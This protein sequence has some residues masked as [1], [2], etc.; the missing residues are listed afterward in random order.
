MDTHKDMDVGRI[1][2]LVCEN[3]HTHARTHTHT[4][5]V[6]WSV[7]FTSHV[8]R[9]LPH[10]HNVL[11][12][13]SL[14]WGVWLPNAVR[15]TGDGGHVTGVW[16]WPGEPRQQQTSLT[17]WSSD[18]ERGR[19]VREEERGEG[20]ERVGWVA[21]SFAVCFLC[22]LLDACGWLW[23]RGARGGGG[24]GGGFLYLVSSV[25][26]VLKCGGWEREGWGGVTMRSTVNSSCSSQALCLFYFSLPPPFSILPH[27]SARG[28]SL[29][30]GGVTSTLLLLPPTHPTNSFPSSFLSPSPSHCLLSSGACMDNQSPIM[31]HSVDQSGGEV[32]VALYVASS[33]GGGMSSAAPHTS[34][35]CPDSLWS[36]CAGTDGAGLFLTWF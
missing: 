3:T 25:C 8:L 11:H 9:W 28:E 26:A 29:E 17:S 1:F 35:Q 12:S 30:F 15:A 2:P 22:L 19:E 4:H 34:G 6:L 16:A 13:L 14:E 36:S 20:E 24:G 32:P 31:G 23:R 7:D 21:R 5:T 10:I 18:R 27:C 33:W